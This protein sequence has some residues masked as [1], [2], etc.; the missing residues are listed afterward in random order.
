MGGSNKGMNKTKKKQKKA[1]DLSVDNGGNITKAMR[2]AKYKEST[3]NNPS[4]LTA[5]KAWELLLEQHASDERLAITLS[6]GL[7]ANKQLATRVIFKKEA[8]TSQSAG[9]LPLASSTTD[10]FI[11]VPD[12]AIRHKYLETGL[13]LKGKLVDKV[14]ANVKMNVIIMTREPRK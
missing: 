1:F 11:E 8:P 6:E 14:E 10:D 3:I 13:K 5:S 12:H 9:E 2:E 4:N 7:E